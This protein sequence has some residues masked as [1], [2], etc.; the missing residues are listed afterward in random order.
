MAHTA[1]GRTRAGHGNRFSPSLL[2]MFRHCGKR[3]LQHRLQPGRPRK[4]PSLRAPRETTPTRGRVPLMRRSASRAG[5]PSPTPAQERDGAPQP[6][7]T[8]SSLYLLAAG[9]DQS[10]THGNEV[11]SDGRYRAMRTSTSSDGAGRHPVRSTS[12]RNQ[13]RLASPAGIQ[14]SPHFNDRRVDLWP[15]QLPNKEAQAIVLRSMR[16][17]SQSAPR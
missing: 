5:R 4:P 11:Q 8:V 13:T 17:W 15:L 2:V 6:G 14:T 12:I 7:Y 3:S 16:Q 1:Y 9:D 10:V